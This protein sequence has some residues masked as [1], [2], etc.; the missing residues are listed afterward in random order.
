MT[1]RSGFFFD[2]RC[3]WHAAGL[4]SLVLPV[5]VAA[6]AKRFR[7][8]RIAGDQAPAEKPDGRVRIE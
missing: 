7:P 4:H 6:A 3:F 8:C 2:E 5:G 1:R